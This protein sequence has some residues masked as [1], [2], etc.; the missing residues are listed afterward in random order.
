MESAR[1]VCIPFNISLP[2]TSCYSIFYPPKVPKKKNTM[3]LR[4]GTKFFGDT[5]VDVVGYLQSPSQNFH[6]ERER[7]RTVVDLGWPMLISDMIPS[8]SP[9]I[10]TNGD[11]TC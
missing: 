4:T 1:R 9:L 10:R 7:L 8:K 11:V 6:H 3:K 2:L 5:G